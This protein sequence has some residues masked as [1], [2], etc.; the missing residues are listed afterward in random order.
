M[1]FVERLTYDRG[2]LIASAFKAKTHPG[3]G[4]LIITRVPIQ[5]DGVEAAPIFGVADPLFFAGTGAIAG[6]SELRNA[7]PRVA[8]FPVGA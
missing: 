1:A 3:A 5:F 2:A 7:G 6:L 4:V 8:F